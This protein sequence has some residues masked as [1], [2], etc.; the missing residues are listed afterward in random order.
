MS[1]VGNVQ[2]SPVA[3]NTQPNAAV[4]NN[5]SNTSNA[6]NS[7][8]NSNTTVVA[9]DEYAGSAAKTETG[10][11][12]SKGKKSNFTVDRAA[13]QEMKADLKN[14]IGAF[15]AMAN[16]IAKN[17]GVGELFGKNSTDADWAKFVEG[18]ATGQIKVTQQQSEEAKKAISDDGYWGVEKT[19][20]RI[21]EFAKSISGGDTAQFDKLM[22]AIDKGFGAA[23]DA[24]GKDM[25]DI[26][27]QTYDKV[28][29]KM[30]AWKEGASTGALTS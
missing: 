4:N 29:E 12:N 15:K 7:Q 11:Y 23:K 27:K 13:I 3:V 30:N 14:N 9:A 2:S 16:G 18:V 19:S 26:T 1:G 22:S 28:K 24:W 25:P 21:V 8:D 20:E 6:A 10:N 5:Q 17:S